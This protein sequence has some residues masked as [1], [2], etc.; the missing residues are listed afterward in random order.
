MK[1]QLAQEYLHKTK[2]EELTSSVYAEA[3]AVLE[4][5]KNPL[6]ARY[7]ASL[8]AAK[9]AEEILNQRQER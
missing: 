4:Q 1:T 2:R 9:K 8:E 7:K 5:V 3:A 6:N